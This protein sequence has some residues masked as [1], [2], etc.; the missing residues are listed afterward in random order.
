MKKYKIIY[1][2][3]AWKYKWGEGKNGGNFCPEKHYDTMSVEDICKLN[4]KNL[5]D[6]N[7][8]LFLWATMPCLPDA[9]KV[10][11][12]WG[13]KYKTCGFTWVKITKAGKPSI[14]LGSYTRSNAELCLIG[15]RGHIKAIDK[16]ISQILIQRR[17]QHSKKPEIIRELI[18]KLFGDCEKVE[19]FARQKV[20]GWDA[21]GNE[22]KSDIIL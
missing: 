2:D 20:D 5:R 13:F 15:M 22:I 17:S 11:N 6:K 14:G 7:C 8:V 10:M 3:P 16:T 12:E 21:W 4:V 9:L 1:A 19:L 18:V